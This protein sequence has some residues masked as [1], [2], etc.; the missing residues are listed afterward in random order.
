MSYLSTSPGDPNYLGYFATPEALEAAYPVGFPGAFALVGSTDTF[1]VWDEDSMAWVDTGDGPAGETGPTGATGA[2][3]ATGVTGA[4]E[5]GPTGPTGP[6]GVTGAGETGPTGPTGDIGPTG[7]TGPTGVTGAGETGAT[8]P[9]GDIGP[10]GPTGVTGAGETGATGPTGATGETGSTGPTGVTGAGTP[11]A[12]GPTG[13]TGP[14]AITVGTTTVVSGTTTRV[15][16]N[17][18]GVVG[19]YTI[20]G[21]G[22]VVAMQTAP[23]FVTNISTPAVLATANDSGALGA[24]GTAFS[25][26]FLASGGVINWNAGNATIIHSAGLLTFNVP[27]TTSG[28]VTATGFS[29]TATTATG[30]RMYLPAANTIGWSING[31]GELQLT[32]TAL[33]PIADGGSSLGTT[34][35]G[36]QNL[37]AN[38]GFVLNIENGNWVAT[39]TS[40][41]LT[42]GTGDLRVT[43]DFTNTRSVVVIGATQTLTNKTLTSP[44]IN[45]ASLGGTQLLAEGASIG[46]DPSA[47]ADGAYSGITITGTSGYT[48]AFGDLVY[49]DPTDSRWEACDANA[50]A[51]ADGDSRGMVGMVV[52]AGT[53]GNSCT[54]LLQGVIRADA[55]FPTFTV[56]NPIYI[57][58]T[59]GDV[60]QTQPVTTDVVIRFLGAALTADSMYFDPD[61]IWFTH[62]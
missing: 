46:L 38:T 36:W 7:P 11:G 40:G 18:A 31:T 6:T 42:V 27:L 4:G 56:N 32:S 1:W 26:L 24:S 35:L 5:T 39:H 33:S 44:V 41:I 15:L 13:A 2:T 48:Q 20:T 10:T 14:N 22:T 12:T 25:D 9:T 62:T 50:A 45:T 17:N 58:E 53:D 43:N 30:N 21:T 28:L 57:S 49:L 54:I 8:G 60:T 52:V 59:A 55:N 16:Y 19:E 47:S 23:V 37:F 29:P 61:K 3:G 51:G 34:T